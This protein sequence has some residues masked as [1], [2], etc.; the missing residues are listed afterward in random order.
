[1]P[2][3]EYKCDVCEYDFE[4]NCKISE[5]KREVNCPMCRDRARVQVSIGATFGDE[6]A[7]IN[8]PEV[9]G[10]IQSP[11]EVLKNPVLTRSEYKKVLSDKGIVERG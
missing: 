11:E 2:T 4:I 10:S 5:Y 1:M 3:Y 9:R 7:W 6:A 8:E